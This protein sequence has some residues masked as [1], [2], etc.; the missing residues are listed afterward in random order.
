MISTH[1]L[2]FSRIGANRELKIALE[3]YWQKK[4]TA[5]DLEQQSRQIR[6]TH[7][8]YQS[9]MDYLC[10][11]DFSLYDQVLDMS[12]RL[13]AI[14]DRFQNLPAN[15]SD[16]D[17]YFA[18]AR[19]F[20]RSSSANETAIDLAACEMTKW[21]DTNY[22]Y[23]VPELNR[24]TQFNLNPNDLIQQIH[25]AKAFSKPLKVTLIGPITYLKLSKTTDQSE[26]L[27]YLD[28]LLDAYDQLL[29]ALHQEG[30][31]W[32]QM[33]EPALTLNLEEP[34]RHAFRSAYHRLH[35]NPAQLLVA[36]YFGPLHEN[37]QLLCELPVAGVH[38]DAVSSPNEIEPL[39]DWLAAPKVISLGI[40]N[41]R[42]I[43]RTDLAAWLETLDRLEQRLEQPLWL[44][45]SCSLLHVPV[46]LALEIALDEELR[47]WLAF[48][49]QKIDELNV[50]KQ[51]L[52]GQTQALEAVQDS[53]VAIAH[54]QT[55]DRVHKPA[56]QA[57]LKSIKASDYHRS[58]PFTERFKQQQR[59]LKLPT[60]PTTTIGSFPQTT[61]IRSVRQRFRKADITQNEYESFIKSCIQTCIEQ[62]E[63]I[64]LDVLVHGEPERNDMVEYFGEALGG[65]AI[66]QKGWVQSYGS[67]CVKPP[68]LYADVEHLEPI[69]C[70]WIQYAQSL[71]SKPV[72]GM[73]TGPTTILNWSFVR[74]DQPLELT[75]KQLAL[76]IRSEVQ[77]LESAGVTIIQVDEAALREGLPLRKEQWEYY[78]TWTIEC[79]R[80]ATSSV[81]ATTQIHTH[82]CYSQFNDILPSI[83]QM[84]A[85]VITIESSRSDGRLLRAFQSF[86]YPQCIG[87]GVYDIHS[88]SIPSTQ[89]IQSQLTQATECIPAE[90]LWV[91]PDCGLKTRRWEEV[92]PSLKHMVQAAKN[93]RATLQEKAPIP[94]N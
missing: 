53:H 41:G 38:L 87:P 88:P 72:K 76:A 5:A 30:V 78:L 33:D 80:L 14:P 42:N 67:R 82:M 74:D 19:G 22:H 32:V 37:L 54:R 86:E 91:N 61:D 12:V 35:A 51:G 73:L 81:Q 16:L 58:E 21:F 93:L 3:K 44:S 2:G 1:I 13:G 34:W 10:V 55:T 69:T 52:A 77:A 84:D 56:I 59:S 62:Q 27:E 25:E 79:F 23:I 9:N 92:T 20:Q 49:K 94:C 46:D 15:S 83:A 8:Q 63:A 68:I 65:F 24:D 31:E 17:R 64:G 75:A 85:D 66:T 4:S 36:T 7:W 89:Q 40:I 43:W 70:Q 28:P 48:G 90:R 57:E 39:C 11:G 29:Q 6:E 18:M 71:T 45:T 47:S 50:L 60:F 26:P